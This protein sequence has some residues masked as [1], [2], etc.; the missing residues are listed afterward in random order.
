MRIPVCEALKNPFHFMKSAL[1]KIM[2]E[3]SAFKI[4]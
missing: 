3:Q 2:P 1:I 4:Q